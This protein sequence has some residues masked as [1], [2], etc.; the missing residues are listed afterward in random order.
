MDGWMYGR[1]DEWMDGW[2]YGWMD[3][4]TKVRTDGQINGRTMDDEWMDIWMEERKEG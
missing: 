4:R 3:R 1:K 2:K